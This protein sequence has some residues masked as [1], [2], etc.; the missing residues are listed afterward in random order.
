MSYWPEFSGTLKRRAAF[1]SKTPSTFN[2][3]YT[4]C[5]FY[6]NY[7]FLTLNPLG[8]GDDLRYHPGTDGAAA[9]T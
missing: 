6:G 4:F 1:L 7:R 3:P 2:T 9:F 5:T 8:S